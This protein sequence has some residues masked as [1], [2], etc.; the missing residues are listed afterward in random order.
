MR[1]RTHAKGQ[2]DQPH[3]AAPRANVPAVL[4][5]AGCV[6]APLSPGGGQK[7]RD[8]T[9]TTRQV[10]KIYLYPYVD[11]WKWWNNG[12]KHVLR[13]DFYCLTLK[14]FMRPRQP[15]ST[16]VFPKHCSAVSGPVLFYP[17]TCPSTP[18]PERQWTH[19][20]PPTCKHQERC[21]TSTLAWNKNWIKRLFF[22]PVLVKL[23]FVNASVWEGVRASAVEHVVL[24]LTFIMS[25]GGEPQGASTTHLWRTQ[26]GH[27][28][29]RWQDR[30]TTTGTKR[31]MKYTLMVNAYFIFT[32]L[33]SVHGSICW[34][35]FASAAPHQP[36]R[37]R[38]DA[39]SLCGGGKRGR[40]S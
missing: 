5:A 38:F 20:R 25:S 30:D 31:V 36:S 34:G 17:E 8:L 6:C 29:E 10:E 1:T 18:V 27:V 2:T 23:T 24:E 14:R 39:L 13:L 40:G 32:P 26:R 15:S 37:C 4:A 9:W 16:R 33:S 28:H 11:L 21:Q 7:P 12:S 19:R 22:L 3:H 35:V